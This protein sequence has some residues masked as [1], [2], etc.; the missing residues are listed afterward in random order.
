VPGP[1][2]GWPLNGPQPLAPGAYGTSHYL[3]RVK[4]LF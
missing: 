4:N 1:R 3:D 2:L